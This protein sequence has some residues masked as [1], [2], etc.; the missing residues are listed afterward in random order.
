[1]IGVSKLLCGTVTPSD[2]LR[3]GRRTAGV[4]QPPA[5]VHDG[6]EAHRGLEQHQACNLACVH[7]YYTARA[8]RDPE[9]ADDG[10]GEDR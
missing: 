2:A 4:A 1:M 10:R 6:Q 8:Q 3:Y 9:R 7:C 5:S